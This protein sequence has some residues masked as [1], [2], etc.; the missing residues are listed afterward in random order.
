MR[1]KTASARECS[2]RAGT[3]RLIVAFLF[4]ALL[5]SL[6]GWGEEIPSGSPPTVWETG[7][8]WTYDAILSFQGGST[9]RFPITLIV[10]GGDTHFGLESWD[11]AGIYESYSGSEI[12]G[13]LR[14]TGP[15]EM[16]LRWP[17]ILNF[18]PGATIS[19]ASDLTH[20]AAA[21][22][23]SP[24]GLPIRIERAAEYT[25]DP[26]F[27]PEERLIPDWLG[28]ED[29][30]FLLE[31][32]TLIPEDPEGI[33][34]PAGAFPNAIPVRYTWERMEQNSGRAFW[35]PELQWW[36]YAE[37][38]EE[39]PDGSPIDSYTIALT[40][41]GVLPQGEIIDRLSAAL[42]SMEA[43]DPEGAERIGEFLKE[44]GLDIQ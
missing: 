17:A 41:F 13:V 29:G 14:M 38:V 2:M 34:T 24:A 19:S 7:T 15:A 8:Y 1:T 27:I 30:R 3:G 40:S 21:V 5:L 39:R 9:Y 32:V 28:E 22:S 44:E 10:L 26:E 11:L 31:A 16:Y 23:L 37:G 42:S 4:L 35:S 33:D 20:Q 36:V 43:T 6:A 18:I 25:A 12:V